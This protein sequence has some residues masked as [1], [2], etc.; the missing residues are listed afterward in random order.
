MPS[1]IAKSLKVASAL[2][3][4]DRC[5]SRE[6]HFLAVSIGLHSPIL[7]TPAQL[8][9]GEMIREMACQSCSVFAPD[10]PCN[11]N[12]RKPRALIRFDPGNGCG[13]AHP[14][15]ASIRNIVPNIRALPAMEL[16][17]SRSRPSGRSRHRIV[18]P[19]ACSASIRRQQRNLAPK[20]HL[21][22]LRA[23][24]VRSRV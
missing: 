11:R 7:E 12:R 2:A 13:H 4:G 17:N 22:W 14:A 23:A 16:G 10:V 21:R 1:G 6:R 5:S 8:V 20:F 3:A 24:A 18:L 9:C 15:L 19:R